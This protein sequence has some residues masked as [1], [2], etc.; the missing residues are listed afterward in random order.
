MDDLLIALRAAG[1][2]TRLRILAVLARSELTVSELCKVLGQTQPR[3]SRHLRLLCEAGL[4]VRNAQGTS[5]F[6]RP[7]RSG[8]GRELFD[9]ILPLIDEDDPGL[10]S[11]LRRLAAIRAERAEIAAAYFEAVAS[12]WNRMRTRHVA[13]DEVEAAM[14]AAVEDLNVSQLLDVGTGTGRVLEVFADHI[15]RGIGLDLSQQM[16]DLARSR[17]DELG[18]RHCSVRQANAYDLGVDAGSVDVAVL[19]HVLHFLDDPV[20]SIAEAAR[21]LRP[22][23]RL[24]IVDFG[25]HRDESMRADYAHHWL[26][27]ADDEVTDWCTNVGLIDVTTQHLTLTDKEDGLTVTLWTA[28]QHQDAPA[29]YNLEAAS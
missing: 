3:V 2:A 21:A 29:L 24:L 16:L 11:D 22:G 5:A 8:R 15:E 4:L 6:Y 25:P 20:A 18:H 23:G 7:A 17:L 26:G 1:E 13:D 27:F 14:I 19:H 12:D 10:Q 9:A 28:T